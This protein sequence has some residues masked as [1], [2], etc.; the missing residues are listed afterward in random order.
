MR[1][2]GKPLNEVAALV[3]SIWPEVASSSTQTPATPAQPQL[4]IERQLGKN[5]NQAYL[6]T[7]RDKMDNDTSILAEDRATLGDAFDSMALNLG[8]D[9][10]A[11]LKAIISRAKANLMKPSLSKKYLQ[12]YLDR[13]DQ[14]QKT[15]EANRE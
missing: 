5:S 3:S 14:Q 9:P 8:K 12:P 10:V 15:K 6:A 11:D 2:K 7:L 4:P 1:T 13:V